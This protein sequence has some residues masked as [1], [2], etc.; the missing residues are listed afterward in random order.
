MSIAG[1][2][3]EANPTTP[4]GPPGRA[5]YRCRGEIHENTEES[6]IRQRR[7]PAGRVGHPRRPGRRVAGRLHA[8]VLPRVGQPG[9]LGSG[10]REEP[11]PAVADR[12]LLDRA[13]GAV[14]FR[15]PLRPGCAA[16]PA[17]RRGDRGALARPA[18]AQ[19]P[20]DRAG[21]GYGLHGAAG[22]LASPGS[23]RGQPRPTEGLS[24]HAEPRSG[25]PRNLGFGGIPVSI[26]TDPASRPGVPFQPFPGMANPFV[27]GD[28]IDPE[29]GH[30]GRPAGPGPTAQPIGAPAAPSRADD[31]RAVPATPAAP[32][33]RDGRRHR[34]GG[35]AQPPPRPVPAPPI[36]PPSPPGNALPPTNPGS[37]GASTVAATGA[38]RAG[39][40]DRPTP[41]RPGDRPRPGIGSQ[42][43]DRG[44]E[45][46]EFGDQGIPF[47]ANICIE[48]GD[49]RRRGRSSRRR[50]PRR[51]GSAPRP[52]AHRGGKDR[53]LAR[54][55]LQ[56]EP[57]SGGTVP[58]SVRTPQPGG[59]P[60]PRRSSP[61]GGQP[62]RRPASADARPPG[63]GTAGRRP[64]TLD[65]GTRGLPD[66]P[67]SRPSISRRLRDRPHEARRGHRTGRR[68][69]APSSTP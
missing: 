65:P 11:R 1:R 31:A 40:L 14:A 13:A 4:G 25:L 49:E 66:V 50:D 60:A 20:A 12:H 51:A 53:M 3:R 69:R 34:A 46:H 29:R 57:V 30:R 18:V 44:P 8:R 56:D 27:P 24:A 48:R 59:P 54:V 37:P 10:L 67:G 61:T 52:P 47:D 19:Q 63:P 5:T 68:P 58:P 26:S 64:G 9:R 15:R 7:A 2:D 43:P 55:A 36:P 45:R 39:H 23:G 28:I 33:A 41:G 16:G 22:I 17:R 32:G 35:G 42:S 38:G 6:E 21:R 62:A